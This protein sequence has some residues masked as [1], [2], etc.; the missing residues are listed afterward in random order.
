MVAARLMSWLGTCCRNWTRTWAAARAAAATAAAAAAV[1]AVAAAIT[2]AAA[3]STA[4]IMLHPLME[5]L[6]L[7]MP[8]TP[9]RL[10]LPAV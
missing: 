6:L 8:L 2:V 3:G 1:V 7:C 5:L 4:G 10:L 9:L